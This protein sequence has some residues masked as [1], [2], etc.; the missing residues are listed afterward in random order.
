MGKSFSL[1]CDNAFD[2]MFA[3]E[4]LQI[5]QS[6]IEHLQN[7]RKIIITNHYST[8]SLYICVIIYLYLPLKKDTIIIQTIYAGNETMP[9]D[10]ICMCLRLIS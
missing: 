3:F 8:G 4:H 1:S 2:E 6:K 10:P 5:K 9:V 7:T